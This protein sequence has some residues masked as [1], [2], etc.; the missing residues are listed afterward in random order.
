VSNSL[1][2]NERPL[3]GAQEIDREFTLLLKS[4]M[5]GF[6]DRDVARSLDRLAQRDGPPSNNMGGTY[7]PPPPFLPDCEK[8]CESDNDLPPVVPQK[9]KLDFLAFTTSVDVETG[10]LLLES[11]WQFLT[12]TRNS[13]GMYGYPDSY[14]ITCDGV[15]YGVLCTGAKHGRHLFSMTGEACS[16]LNDLDI[17]Y[18]HAALTMDGMDVRLSRVD[19]C[20]DVFGGVTWDHARRHYDLGHFMRP[21]AMRN[22]ELKEIGVSCDGKNKGR[23]MQVGKR[24]GHVVGRIYEKGL[25]VYA[26]LPEHLRL[27]SEEREDAHHEPVIYAD[28][29]LRLE[30]E[31]K[32]DGDRELTFDMLLDRDGYFAGSFPYFADVLGVSDGIRPKG[33]KKQVNVDLLAMIENAKRS[34]GSLVHSLTELGFTPQDVVQHLSSGRNNDKLVKSGLLSEI[35]EKVGKLRAADPDFDIPF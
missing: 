6:V 21:K 11:I 9:T 28:D 10:K 7:P 32:R 31:Y 4:N 5:N 12:Y 3:T 29:W 33:V 14:S 25:E 24:S 1:H 30:V 8:Q 34:Y 27:L 13:K 18:A 16:R 26:K 20:L 2:Q 19:I 17:Q 35:K 22:P 23:T 15:P